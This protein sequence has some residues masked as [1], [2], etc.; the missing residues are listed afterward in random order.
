MLNQRLEGAV[1]YDRIAGYFRSSLFEVAGEAIAKVTGPV[2]IICNSD[3]DPQDLVTA[4]AAQAA[5]RRSWCSG[6]PE[7]APPSAIPRYRALYEALTSKKMEVRV[8]PDSAFGL[9]HGKAGVVRRADGSAT[10]FL[11][12]VNESASAWKVNYELLWED[13]DPETIAWVQEE[14]DA[15]W[16]D[17]RAVDLA[18]CP[19]IAQDVQRIISRRVIEP[20]DLKAI[21][22][23]TAAAAAAAVETPVYRREQGL[24]PHQKY[25]ARLALERHRL[26]GARLVLADQVGLGKTIQLAMAAM[27]MALDDPDG[28][29]ILV[30][31][32]KPLLQQWQDE[33]MEL[34]LLPSARWNGR[35]W[36]DEN[37]LEYP[38]EGPKSLGKCPRRIGLVSQGLVVRGLSEAVNQL[39]SR[40]YTCVIVDESHRARRR[41]VPKVDAGADEID[42]RAEPNKLMAFLREIGP[43]TKSMLLATATPVQLHPVEAWDLLHILSHGNDSVLGGWTQ[44]SPWFRPSHCLEIATGDAAVPT[45][46][47]AMAG[48]TSA[49]RCRPGLKIRHSTASVAALMP[50]TPAG[51]STPRVSINSRQ[52]SG[53]SN[54]RTGCS[55]TTANAS[56]LCCDAS[57]AVRVAIWKRRSIRQR[58]AISC[59]RSTVKLFGEE[60]EGALVLGGYLLEAYQEAEAFSLLLQQRVQGAGF[61]KTLLLRRLGSSMEAGRRTVSKLLGEEPDIPDD[62]DDDD[63]E[64]E[65]P[66]Q[67]GRPPQGVERFQEL[68][69]CGNSITTPLPR[70]APARRQ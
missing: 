22:D 61:F 35:A 48:N 23:P 26:G 37:D 58:A 47:S 2:R 55:P 29:P 30:L 36:V 9:I 50:A 67:V 46:M 40:R 16:N 57:C 4:A 66:A 13:N 56:I 20:E 28:G 59:R 51:N 27:L 11:G 60:N 41:K 65:A 24:W 6:R 7:E 17:A 3:L 53:G 43:K 68:H 42:E 18:C 21:A 15:L 14:F 38:S 64:E 63:A 25:F 32:P 33:L 12:S 1:S 52:R 39:L 54:S 62:E 44:T 34:L 69:R 10:A 49:T 31:A 5:L 8:L 19:F 70:S 45:M